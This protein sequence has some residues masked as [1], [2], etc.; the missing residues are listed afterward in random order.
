[1]FLVHACVFGMSP[2]LCLTLR[3]ALPASRPHPLTTLCRAS[4]GLALLA[5]TDK[6]YTGAANLFGC[7]LGGPDENHACD[8]SL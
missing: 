6:P 1:M 8:C 4:M 3:S 5:S 2:M 7:Q